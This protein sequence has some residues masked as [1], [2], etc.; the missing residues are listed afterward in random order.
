MFSCDIGESLSGEHVTVFVAYF[1]EKA[2]IT[3]EL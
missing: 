1:K 3:G 2:L